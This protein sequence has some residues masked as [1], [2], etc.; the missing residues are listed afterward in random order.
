MFTGH[1]NWL[2]LAYGLELEGILSEDVDNIFHDCFSTEFGFP[3]FP[4][5]YSIL[6]SLTDLICSSLWLTG[7][8]KYYWKEIV[9]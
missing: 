1:A 9:G 5:F 2:P 8:D 4:Q 6:E 7:K 3:P